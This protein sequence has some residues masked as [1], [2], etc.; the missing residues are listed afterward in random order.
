[1]YLASLKIVPGA[2]TP[3]TALR[4]A[5]AGFDQAPNP[6]LATD[7]AGHIGGGD[8]VYTLVNGDPFGF[9]IFNV[10]QSGWGTV[11]YLS[12]II[13]DPAH[14][15]RGLARQ[16]I[17]FAR[18]DAAKL[19]QTPRHLT[20]RTQSPRMWRTGA[21]L[22][23]TWLPDPAADCSPQLAAIGQLTAERIGSQFPVHHGCYGGPLYGEQPTHHDPQLQRWWDNL[24]DFAAG[25]A[26]ICVGQFD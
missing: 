14:Q 3:A 21:G 17:E 9:A 12:G 11:L 23:R 25:D 22:C 26:V 20:L 4:I 15:H 13:L 16:V 18:A 1:M 10:W 6:Q 2:P 19:G 8:L 5:A 24:C 7:V